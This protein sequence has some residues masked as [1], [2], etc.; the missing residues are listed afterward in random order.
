M[1]AANYFNITGQLVSVPILQE[2]ANGTQFT[3]AVVKVKRP[4]SNHKKTYEDDYIQVEL[5][6]GNAETICNKGKP[7]MWVT[8]GGYIQGTKRGIFF[9][10]ESVIYIGKENTR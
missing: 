2:N 3:T 1:S 4:Y 9:V 10:G 5:W 8:I 7:G 6:K